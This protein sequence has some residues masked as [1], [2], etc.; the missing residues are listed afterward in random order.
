MK[1]C[2]RFEVFFS[3]FVGWGGVGGGGCAYG[4]SVCVPTDLLM[5][6]VVVMISRWNEVTMQGQE[7]REEYQ[8]EFQPEARRSF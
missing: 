3:S 7:E 5:N 6:H 4:P 1:L 8:R 2:G